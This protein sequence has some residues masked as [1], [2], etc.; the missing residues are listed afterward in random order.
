MRRWNLNACGDMLDEAGQSLMELYAKCQVA[1]IGD[2]SCERVSIVQPPI[3]STGEELTVEVS[4]TAPD[5]DGQT[6]LDLTLG[7][8]QI[9]L[10]TT[11]DPC[12]LQGNNDCAAQ[13]ATMFAVN[14]PGYGT[15]PLKL[16]TLPQLPSSSPASQSLSVRVSVRETPCPQL[17]TKA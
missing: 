16:E 11:A 2:G 14:Q 6:T 10:E 3:V 8:Q 4:L 13:L 1:A 9:T 7:L 12:V 15:R 17:H 5:T